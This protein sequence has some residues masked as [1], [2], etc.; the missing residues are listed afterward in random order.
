MVGLPCSLHLSGRKIKNKIFN[1]QSLW[2]YNSVTIYN[3]RVWNMKIHDVKQNAIIKLRKFLNQL[4]IRNKKVFAVGFNKSGTTSLHALFTTMKRP[5]Y[6]GIQWRDCDNHKL[7][8]TYDCFSDGIPKDIVKLDRLFPDSKY[9]LQVRDLDTWVYSRLAHIE[10]GKKNLKYET[11]LEWDNTEYA[12]K[13]WIKKRNDHHLFVLSYFF[14]RPSD[15][16]IIN[17]IR[18]NSAAEKISKFL[19]YN[20]KIDKPKKNV[21]PNK[22]PLL[23]HTEMLL[24][25]IAE[26]NIPEHELKYDIYCPSINKTKTH[27]NFPFDSSSFNKN[28]NP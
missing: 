26:L 2:P 6:H 16:L 9:I 15:L 7:L 1:S 3:Y 25:C 21:N 28:K 13:A 10:R 11:K 23:K 24:N 27:F 22:E 14:E 20:G 5:S 19:N 12:I 18:D 4:G 17:F 8:K